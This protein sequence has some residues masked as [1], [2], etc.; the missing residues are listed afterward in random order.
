VSIS[1]DR[2]LAYLSSV[3]DGV[4]NA[5]ELLQ[6][7]EL[8]FIRKDAVQNSQNKARYL[9]LIFDLLE[10]GAST[11]VYEAASALTALTS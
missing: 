11:V 4:P 6:L 8:E 7:V 5:D 3:F 10:A 2:S 9:R 1:H